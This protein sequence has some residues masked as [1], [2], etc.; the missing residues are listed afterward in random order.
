MPSITQRTFLLLL[1]LWPAALAAQRPWRLVEEQRIGGAD[2]GPTSFSEIRDIAVDAKGQLFVLDYKTQEIRLFDASGKFVRLVGREGAGPGEYREPN[3][4]RLAPDGKLWVNDHSN[5]RF[6]VF[7]GAGK[8]DRHV[9]VNEWGFGSDWRAEFDAKGRLMEVISAMVGG[10]RSGVIRRFDPAASKWDT[11]PVPACP[12]RTEGDPAE[13]SWSYRTATGGGIIGVPFAP[14]P[15]TRLDPSGGWW[16]TAG[17]SYHVKLVQLEGA[18]E[19]LD[20]SRNDPQ[21]ALSSVA[22]DSAIA[23]LQK[24]LANVPP[25]TIDLSKVP[26]TQ[27]RFNR[28]AVDDQRRLWVFRPG[29]GGPAIDV[30][31]RNGVALGTMAGPRVMYDGLPVVIRGDR[32]YTVMLDRD[33]VPS[34]VRYRIVQQ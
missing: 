31:S 21:V 20:I 34:V 8:V 24:G 29:V 4:M 12:I 18:K 25:G 27:P 10:A 5:S 3:G 1:A 19:L 32:F 13:W 33:D 26:H 15:I 7:T 17:A 9:M 16:C 30:W 23:N 2:S 28:L 11:I 14:R 22:R 6:V